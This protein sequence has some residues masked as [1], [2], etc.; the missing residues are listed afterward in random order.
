[1]SP[2]RVPSIG[3]A[4]LRVVAILVG[5]ASGALAR[6]AV[7]RAL[8]HAAG[9][10]PWATFSVNLAGAMLL[11][12]LTTR[13]AEMVAPTRY[14]RLGLGTGLCGALTTFSTFQVETISLARDRHAAMAVGY[15]A[16][17]LAGGMAVAILATVAARGRR[18][19]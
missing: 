18:Y 9:T 5:G 11:A 3:P 2:P 10:W 16:A 13:L 19:G 1:V 8:P 17:S 7:A 15:G 6:A 4:R 14:W 12:W